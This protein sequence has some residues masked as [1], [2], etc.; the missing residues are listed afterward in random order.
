[1][2]EFLFYLFI[3]ILAKKLLQMGKSEIDD[4]YALIDCYANVLDAVCGLDW[5]KITISMKI[6]WALDIILI[7]EN[8][9][10]LVDKSFCFVFVC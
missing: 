9:W 10:S 7:V 3:I 4:Y 1:M 5:S 6:T 8:D 2:H